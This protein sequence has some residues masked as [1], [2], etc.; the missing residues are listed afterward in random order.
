MSAELLLELPRLLA[1][2]LNVA[3]VGP[4]AP[5]RVVLFFDTHEAF[6]GR[7]R[8]FSANF[9]RDGWLRRLLRKLDLTAGIVVVVAGRDRPRWSEADAYEQNTKIPA[10]YICERSVEE[11]AGSDAALYLEK[12]GIGEGALRDRLIEYA[13]VESGRVH[14]LH[15]GLCADVVLEAQAKGIALGP[16]EF[17]TVPEFQEKSAYLIGQ[18]LKYVDDNLEHAIRALGACRSFDFEIYDLLGEALSYSTDRAGFERLVGFSFVRRVGEV[19]EERCRIHD[20]LRRLGKSAAMV[21]AH[22]VLAEHYQAQDNIDA[23]YHINQLDWEQ[24]VELWLVKFDEA[25]KL[26]RYELCRALLELRT[27]LNIETLFKL[28]LLANAEGQ[29]LQ[30]LSFYETA[31]TTFEAAI[32]A[33][34]QD[35]ARDA[36]SIATL[37]NK[38]NSLQRL[39]NL[40]ATLSEH[41]AARDSY[42]ESIA[43]YDAVLEHNPDD[44]YALNNKGLSLIGLAQVQ[45]NQ[46]PESNEM[47]CLQA[48]LAVFQRVLV[49]S[50]HNSTAREGF[51][52]LAQLFN[53][54]AD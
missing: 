20:L 54:E 3:M 38:G 25:L 37:N 8:N 42:A 35:L 48:A 44:V 22:Q 10:E 18:L 2:D 39:A 28:G 41:A 24:G 34:D 40:Q 21:E 6:Y 9:F 33:Y 16:E 27:A 23:I 49:I 32:A 19:T 53:S 43:A 30:T 46:S 26:S 36:D 1:Q 50:P 47:V 5:G 13:S 29:Y 52:L 4:T 14:P 17:L 15:L 31:R 11:L 45:I 51:N 7:D 12:A